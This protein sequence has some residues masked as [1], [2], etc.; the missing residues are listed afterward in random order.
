MTGFLKDGIEY[1]FP[2]FYSAAFGRDATE[3]ILLSVALPIVF[4]ITSGAII[5]RVIARFLRVPSV[6]VCRAVTFI[7]FSACPVFSKYGKAA[8]TGGICST[9]TYVGAICSY[10]MALISKIFNW[11]ATIISRTIVAGVGMLFTLLAL[12]SYTKFIKIKSD[13]GETNENSN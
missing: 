1:R 8:T 2:T 7:S 3:S 10:A 13:F 11:R 6:P 12:R 5:S 9:F 4:L